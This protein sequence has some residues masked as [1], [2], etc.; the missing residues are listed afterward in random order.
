E[1]AYLA[2]DGAKD[3]DKSVYSVK[4]TKADG[5]ATR[6]I[7]DTIGIQGGCK[8]NVTNDPAEQLYWSATGPNGDTLLLAWAPT[9]MLYYSLGCNGV[10]IGQI[11]ADGSNKD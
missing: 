10:G 1:V 8:D 3:G 6:K 7:G 4:A 5:S 9:N 2:D 11:K